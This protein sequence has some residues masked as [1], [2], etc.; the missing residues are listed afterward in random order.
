MRNPPQMRWSLC[1]KAMYFIDLSGTSLP[2]MISLPRAKVKRRW[3][4]YMTPAVLHLTVMSNSPLGPR[5]SRR[6]K[7]RRLRRVFILLFRSELLELSPSGV[8]IPRDVE[9]VHLW[10]Y[11]LHC[12][13]FSRIL[14]G[15]AQPPWHIW[16]SQQSH[17]SHAIFPPS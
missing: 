2:P 13:A 14:W 8:Y 15:S 9:S 16:M 7:I 6:W 17:I 3:Q 4:W 12:R 11:F 5:P 10:F 1:T